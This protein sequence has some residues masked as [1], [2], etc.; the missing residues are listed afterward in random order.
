MDDEDSIDLET[1]QAQIDMSMSFAQEMVSSW[2][3][4]SRKLPKRTRDVDAEL[5]DYLR[6]PPRLGVGATIPEAASSSRDVARLK[7]HLVGKGKKRP[8]ENELDSKEKDKSESESEGR[9]GSMKKKARVDPFANDGKKKKKSK[10]VVTPVV[11]P[12]PEVPQ[13]V[14]L[15]RIV[16]E[17]EQVAVE[18]HAIPKEKKEETK[19]IQLDASSQQTSPQESKKTSRPSNDPSCLTNTAQEVL[20]VVDVSLTTTP[21]TPLQ[22]RRQ[23]QTAALLQHPLLNLAP[24]GDTESEHEDDPQLDVGGSSSKKK[25]KRKKKKKKK[26]DD[27][28]LNDLE[29]RS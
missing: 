6:R 1:L 13:A 5:K 15:D 22:L 20:K 2:V 23:A 18:R 9:G 28:L 24:P 12:R 25:R 26:N 8:R 27:S 10:T 7:G 4:P 11:P 14:K 29:A 3:K 16:N 19:V 21:T 17:V